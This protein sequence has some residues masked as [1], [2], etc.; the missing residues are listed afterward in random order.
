MQPR[1][2]GEQSV[3]SLILT[4]TSISQCHAG[5]QG[6][7]AHLHATIRCPLWDKFPRTQLKGISFADESGVF[8]VL[9]RQLKQSTHGLTSP[10][11]PA[12]IDLIPM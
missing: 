5:A 7:S 9:K 1:Q 11:P 6:P 10:D 3:R 12:S 2:Q 4:A 8:L